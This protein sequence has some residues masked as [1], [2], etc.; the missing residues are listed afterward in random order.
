MPV[1]YFLVKLHNVKLS[2]FCFANTSLSL[3]CK[4][5]TR[6]QYTFLSE[7]PL[8]HFATAPGV[9][10]QT[11]PNIIFVLSYGSFFFFFHFLTIKQK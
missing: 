6:C 5:A 1:K 9:C 4:C 7:I 2:N 8:N 11:A 10:D 3:R